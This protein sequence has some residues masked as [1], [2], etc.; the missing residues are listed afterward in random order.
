MQTSAHSMKL[1]WQFLV[2]IGVTNQV[3]APESEFENS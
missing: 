3:I 1:A 2:E